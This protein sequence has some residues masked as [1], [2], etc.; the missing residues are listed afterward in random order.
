MRAGIDAAASCK[1]LVGM[2]TALLSQAAA[3]AS[4][5]V[6]ASL[7]GMGQTIVGPWGVVVARSEVQQGCLE[8]ADA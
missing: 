1:Q 4:T 2:L 6:D 7:R 5:W 3:Q 8:G